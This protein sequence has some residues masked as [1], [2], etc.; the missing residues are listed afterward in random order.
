MRQFVFEKYLYRKQIRRR[1]S[2]PV[3]RSDGSET[4]V[5]INIDLSA[6]K[7]KS[8]LRERVLKAWIQTWNH[9][10]TQLDMIKAEI[11]SVNEFTVSLISC[12]WNV[13]IVSLPV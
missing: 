10:E 4:V 11:K 3:K 13:A 9:I 5:D 8:N 7:V 6:S 1:D 2:Q 12:R